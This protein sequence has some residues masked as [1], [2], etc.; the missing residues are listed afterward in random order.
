MTQLP[1]ASAAMLEQHQH[2]IHALAEDWDS[3]QDLVEKMYW[4]ELK[5]LEPEARVTQYLPLVTSRRVR[6]LLRN[7][8]RRLNAAAAVRKS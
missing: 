4:S 8:R 1:T 5:R 3:P 6:E 2:A 7:N